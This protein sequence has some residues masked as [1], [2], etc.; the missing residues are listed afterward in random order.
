MKSGQTSDIKPNCR[1]CKNAGPVDNFMCACSVLGIN[2]STGVRTC[3]SF[4][5]DMTKYNSIK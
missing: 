4:I 3:S 2:R 5:V 1:Y